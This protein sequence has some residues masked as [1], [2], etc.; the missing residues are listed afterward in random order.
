MYIIS[1]FQIFVKNNF[2]VP[3]FPKFQEYYE[4]FEIKNQVLFLLMVNKCC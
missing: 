2:S 1:N 4:A 3:E